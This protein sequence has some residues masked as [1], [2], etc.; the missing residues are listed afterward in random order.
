MSARAICAV[1]TADIVGSSSIPDLVERRDQ[2][3]ETLSIRHLE[4]HR[5]LGRYTVTAWD[6]FQNV[7]EFPWDLPDV[8]W[9]LQLSFRPT[10]EVRIGVGIGEIQELPGP[11]TAINEVSSGDAFLRAR[12]A[13]ERMAKS[14]SE[15]YPLRTLVCSADPDLDRI[16]NLDFMLIDTLLA[17]LSDR[18]WETTREY[19]ATGHL[20]RAAERLAVNASTVSRNLQR[21]FYWQLLDARRQLRELLR[22]RLHVG[23]RSD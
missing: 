21:G 12:E 11:E 14:E 16:L 20:G 10:L 17:N 1:V 7:L 23:V 4:N 2:A 15:K 6:E 19:H 18:Q 8:I 3:L 9:D 5:V 13:V 22:S